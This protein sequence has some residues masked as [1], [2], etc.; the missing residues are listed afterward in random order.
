MTKKNSG[1]SL[2]VHEECDICAL[3]DLDDLRKVFRKYTEATGFPVVLLDHP[4]MS[5]LIDTGWRDVCSEFHRECIE[6]SF[7]CV[8]SR[9]HLLSLLDKPG[10]AILEECE[11]GLVNCA[12][13]IT[14]RDKHIASLVIG[15]V[16]I[17]EPDLKRFRRQAKSFGYNR[18][19][20]LKSLKHVPV[21]S[22]NDLISKAEFMGEM[23][24]LVLEQVARETKN[25]LLENDTARDI[26][27]TA[28]KMESL[29]RLAGGIAHD[30]NNLLTVILGH[31]EIALQGLSPSDKHYDVFSQIH[32]TAEGSATLTRQLL[33]FARK[34]IVRPEIL[35][36]ND[37]ISTMFN[38]LRRLIGEQVDLV[39][40]PGTNLWT[41]EM[42]PGQL[43][44]ILVNLC[45]NARDAIDGVGQI[46]IETV[47]VIIDESYCEDH[48]GI[49]P[50]DYMR[51][52]VRDSGCGIDREVVGHIFE[53]FFT[54]RGI[55]QNSG[56][57]LATVYGIVK[58]NRGY[59]DVW[60]EQEKGTAIH[61][62]LPGSTQEAAEKRLDFSKKVPAGNGEC[63]LL[64]EDDV[65]VLEMTQTMLEGLNYIVLSAGLP[66]M[67]LKIVQRHEGEIHL[68]LTD[69]VMPGMNGQELA[70]K[71]IKV[72]PYTK[73]LFMSGYSFP[74]SDHPEKSLRFI[75]KPF[76][77]L[78][79]AL[80]VREVLEM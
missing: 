15:Q 19:G 4:G 51:L 25:T 20:Y 53:P 33:A 2:S 39:W 59:V 16:F 28:H 63:I 56:L 68:L 70:E 76:S 10:Q 26:P 31:T 75:Q 65:A 40:L 45:V 58:Q 57:G 30:F 54:T 29:G 17:E 37:S 8:R 64:V 55:G 77:M 49:I 79:L 62:Y 38:M 48:L 13:P 41:A 60:S 11:H 78:D 69:L 66:D 80:K 27:A 9:R 7:G 1:E 61:I 67:A 74:S 36:V 22:R 72:S 42:D 52:T 5:I 43:D 32:H 46:R 3:V 18:S 50:G 23:V 35:N 71:I 14:I 34:Q 12:I 21:V 6:S 47:N 44:Q 24:Q 73:P